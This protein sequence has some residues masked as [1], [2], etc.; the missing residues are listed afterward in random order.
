MLP[1]LLLPLKFLLPWS[2][3]RKAMSLQVI[4]MLI[5]SYLISSSSLLIFLYY[6]Y[7]ALYK[8]PYNW[9][10]L[11]S[12][13]KFNRYLFASTPQAKPEMSPFLRITLWQG[14][15]IIMGFLPFQ[16]SYCNGNILITSCFSIRNFL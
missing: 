9:F 11:F 7:C 12:L 8:F 14:T 1:L 2:H 3:I 13:S 6:N 10:M 15:T 5:S 16:I 4:L